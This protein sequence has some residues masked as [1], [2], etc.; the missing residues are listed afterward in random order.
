MKQT[1]FSKITPSTVKH[2]VVDLIRDAI[3]RGELAPSEHL[4]EVALS[5]QMA[6]SRAP[7]REAL[8]QLEL[9]GL[10]TNFPNR[11]CFVT[12]F[13]EQ[14]VRE[15]F[16][17]RAALEGMAIE[18][19]MPRLDAADFAALRE[20][21]S[22]QREAIATRRLDELTKLD[23]RFHEYIC[24]KANNSRMLKAWYAQSAQCQMLMNRRFRILSDYTPGTVTSD[25]AAIL[26]ALKRGDGATALKLTK[27]I[28]E[29]V[30][31]ELIEI[32]QPDK[33]LET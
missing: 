16:S 30:Q 29:R 14:D 28:S 22:A 3:I 33:T 23:M 31:K 4:T 32:L 13:T 26:N 17:L 24:I 9:E 6:V 5:A 7:I 1:V 12:V 15:V 18:A 11:G 21:I 20:T 2:K 25:H 19:A 10:I 8:R 27:Q